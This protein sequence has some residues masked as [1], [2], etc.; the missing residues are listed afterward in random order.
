MTTPLHPGAAPA[1]A[2]RQRGTARSRKSLALA[3]QLRRLV[4]LGVPQLAGVEESAFTALAD[5]LEP[6]PA[7]AVVVV[8]PSLVPARRLAGLLNRSGKPG[9][10]VADMTDLED[11]TPIP[12][13]E[14]PDRPLYLI[15]DLDRGDDLRNQSP[16]EAMAELRARGRRPLTVSEGVSWL[17]QEPERLEPNHCFMTIASRK[18][19]DRSATTA[20]HSGGPAYDARVPALWISGGTGRDGAERRGAPKIGWCW[21][22]NRHTW[23]G[24]ASSAPV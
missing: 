10:V 9:F 7:T 3:S 18:L 16:E 2:V 8:H 5:G 1:S 15:E 23:L 22:R 20:R 13:V 11:F 4:D 21:A 17:L 12:E 24:F 6:V 19:A 14:V